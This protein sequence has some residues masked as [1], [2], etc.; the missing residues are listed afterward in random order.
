MAT[1]LCPNEGKDWICN[2]VIAGA[3][4]YGFLLFGKTVAGSTLTATTDLSAIQS[5]S[6]ENGTGYTRKS[7]TLGSSTDGIMAIPTYNWTT[8]SATNWHSNCQ[9]IGI[10]T[11]ATAGVALYYWD[12]SAT[13]NMSAASTTL[14]IPTLDIFFLNPG[15]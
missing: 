14:T 13:R 2:N 10:A 15:E 6:E 7:V 8:G 12:L 11:H 4:V 3:T 1:E 5:G 9:A